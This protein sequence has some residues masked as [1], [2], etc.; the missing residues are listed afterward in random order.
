MCSVGVNVKVGVCPQLLSSF[1]IQCL[2]KISIIG[3]STP[4]FQPVKWK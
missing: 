3:L 4:S 1:Y 2:A